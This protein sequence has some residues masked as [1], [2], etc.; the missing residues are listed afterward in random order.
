M[1]KLLWIQTSQKH[2]KK[3]RK[4]VQLEENLRGSPHLTPRVVDL[5]YA[6]YAVLSLNIFQARIDESVDSKEDLPNSHTC[7]GCRNGD[8]KS[9]QESLSTLGASHPRGGDFRDVTRRAER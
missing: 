1:K 4:M 8:T 2:K 3:R 7:P 5:P 9:L 6:P